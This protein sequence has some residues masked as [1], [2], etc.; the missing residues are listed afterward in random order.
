MDDLPVFK[1]SLS[2]QCGLT[3]NLARDETVG[4]FNSFTAVFATSDAEIYNYVNITHVTNSAPPANGKILIL[5]SAIFALKDLRFEL[6]DRAL[7][8]APP[9]LATLQALDAV[10]LNYMH[11]QRTN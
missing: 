10:Q 9:V 5:A 4:C 3:V 6:E 2:S 7:C 8:G 11:A 1:N